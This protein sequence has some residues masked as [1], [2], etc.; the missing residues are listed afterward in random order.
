MSPRVH[1][2][3]RIILLALL[4]SGVAAWLIPSYFSAERYHRRLQAG[5]ERTLHR[6]VTFGRVSVRVL[7]RPGF[8][9]ENAVI[10]EDPAFGSEPFVRVDRI[11]CDVRWRTLFGA[12][13]DFSH[14]RLQHP[15][16][17]LV[18]K[19]G[20]GWNVERLF[21]VL[22]ATG[23]QDGGLR[24]NDRTAPD[25][26]SGSPRHNG[27]GPPDLEV[28]DGRVNFKLGEN[29]KLLAIT[30]LEAHLSFD[31][32]HSYLRFQL[33]GYPV[34][35]DLPLPSPGAVELTGE[36]APGRDLRGPLNAVVRAREALV[37]D[38]A[39]LVTD[40]DMGLYGVVD[41]EMRVTGSIR[42]LSFEGRGR[43][44]ELHRWD[45]IPPSDSMPWT[46]TFRGQVDRDRGR[47]LL[48]TIE[49]S[50]AGSHIHLSGTIDYFPSSPELDLVLAL[51]RSRLE[52]LIALAGRLWT[53]K[54]GFGIRGRVDGMLAIQGPWAEPRYGGFVG[55]RNVALN[56]RGAAYPISE[57]AV[58]IDN[59]G[60]HLAPVH[61]TLAPR[62]VLEAE[63]SLNRGTNSLPYELTLSCKTVPLRDVLNFGRALGLSTLQ[64]W[65]ALGSGT[66]SFHLTGSL[67]PPIRPALKGRAELRAARLVIP[68][69]TA[70]INIPRASLQ[71]NGHEIIVDHLLA[72]LG[73]SVFSGRLEHQGDR[74]TPWIFDLHTDALDLQQG[75][76]WFVALPHRNP[77]PLVRRFPGLAS[78][79]GE[80]EVASN[81]F[82]SLNTRGH[83]SAAKI[84]FRETKLDKFQT[85]VEI[86][87]RV[88]RLSNAKFQMA[89]A[90]GRLNGR[91]DLNGRP[92]R[93]AGDVSLSGV[94]VQVIVPHLPPVLRPAHGSISIN[95]H[96]ETAG[97]TQEEM[98]Q[99]LEGRVAVV[100]RDLSLPGFD[101]VGAFVS[102]AGEGA[103]EP[104]RAPAALR[105]LTLNFQIQ[106]RQVVLKKTTLEFSGARLSLSGSQAFDGPVTLHVAADLQRLRR[107]WL[108][109][110]DQ[111]DPEAPRLE[112]DFTGSLDK[113]APT[114]SSQESEVR[115]PV[116]SDK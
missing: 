20:G 86:S 1:R 71:V 68:G 112:L 91:V 41:A 38:W 59:A 69:F 53:L 73:T 28:E 47:V 97:L 105:S 96:F 81:L 13:L 22:T 23:L 109:R 98:R 18:R 61:V 79:A 6:Q 4:L 49:A 50:F 100:A 85:S 78:F 66:A 72:V 74:H 83:F 115:T 36:W 33:L 77:G 37:Y 88:V 89:G 27:A 111:A 93:L 12:R 9:I 8:V 116:T 45:Q 107:R 30:G 48:E 65:N 58:R 25:P 3:G 42:A 102:L 35:A 106:D 80:R 63:G 92:A 7:P 11:E 31:P 51:E 94:G 56:A 64:G 60:A 52:D 43:L 95:G 55:A 67:I 46:M 39:P 75:A 54:G 108:S 21:L 90:Q 24:N 57:L 103:L 114:S 101:P 87:G 70:P 62:V 40:R 17:N 32:T 10:Q 2:R 84:T 44:S 26:K 19:E 76:S 15:N 34:R 29:K 99:N 104:L 110:V 82:S 14:F 16:I 5:L 113:L